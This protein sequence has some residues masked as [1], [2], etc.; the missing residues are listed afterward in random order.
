M[1]FGLLEIW[2]SMGVVARL[3]VGILAAM[4]V[5]SITVAVDRLWFLVFADRKGREY[6]DRVESLA[7]SGD[8]SEAAAVDAEEAGAYGRVMRAGFDHHRKFLKSA[9]S[10]HAAAESLDGVF[11]RALSAEGPRLRRGLGALATIG[12]T[13]PFV[14]LFGT[15][16]GII[17]SFSEIARTGAGGMET[18][19]GGIAEAL[20][21]TALG[22]VVA[23]PA[24]VFF[25]A[26]NLRVETI[27]GTIADL[28]AGI[29]DALRRG[30]WEQSGRNSYPEVVV[31]PGSERPRDRDAADED[32]E[33]DDDEDGEMDEAGQ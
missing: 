10:A 1:Q 30:A 5:V 8:L 13:A 18:V 25:N 12:S 22:I 29:V 6:A 24:V 21:A 32:A 3:V 27:E 23:V 9:P 26:F 20:V 2:Q 17:N 4:S 16:V 33:E 19:S 15:V 11:E 7:E 14:G 31:M 28:T